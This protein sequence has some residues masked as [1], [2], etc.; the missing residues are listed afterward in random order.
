MKGNGCNYLVVLAFIGVVDGVVWMLQL[1]SP[2]SQFVS[3]SGYLNRIRRPDSHF[4]AIDGPVSGD[5]NPMIRSRAVD[6][7]AVKN[8]VQ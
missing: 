5:S 6:T 2:M 7:R 8:M 4:I 3:H 1:K